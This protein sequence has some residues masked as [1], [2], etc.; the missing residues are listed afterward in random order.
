[1]NKIRITTHRYAYMGLAYDTIIEIACKLKGEYKNDVCFNHNG[2][3][4]TLSEGQ[5]DFE[6]VNEENEIKFSSGASICWD[7]DRLE[8]SLSRVTKLMSIE[9]MNDPVAPKEQYT[10]GSSDYYKVFVKNP[11]TLDKPYEAECNDIIEALQMNFAE[12]NAFKAIWR[13][14]KARQGVKKKGYDNGVYDSEKVIFFGERML[15]EAKGKDNE[16]V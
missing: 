6:Y 15:I 4:W 7:K 16:P 3:Q 12:G 8:N 5:G 10:G 9:P 11:T 14:A 1:M 2:K 13:K